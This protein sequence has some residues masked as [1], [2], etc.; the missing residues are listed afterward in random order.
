MR[1]LVLPTDP[2]V[3]RCPLFRPTL[4]PEQQAEAQRITEAL[5]EAA[6][7]GVGAIAELLASKPDDQ[8]LGKTEYEVRDRVHRIGAKAIETARNGAEVR[9]RR[10]GGPDRPPRPPAQPPGLPPASAHGRRGDDAPPCP[11]AEPRP[12]RSR[13]DETGALPPWFAR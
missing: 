12:T 11:Q 3:R 4:T 10:R 5:M 13:P 6:R 8:P 7:E 9:I 2:H 1:R